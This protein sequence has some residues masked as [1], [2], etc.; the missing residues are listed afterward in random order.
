MRSAKGQKG[1][2]LLET[3]IS[4]PILM[5]L[6][7]ASVA[8]LLISVRNYFRVLAD[9]ELHQE[10]QIAFTRMVQDLTEAKYVTPYQQNYPGIELHKRWYAL[11][12]YDG[13]TDF[14]TLYWI[15]EVRGRKKLIWGWD[16]SAPMTGDYSLAGVEIHEIAGE[17]EASSPGL[18]VL[19]LKG[20]SVFTNHYYTLST[21]VYLPRGEGEGTDAR[22]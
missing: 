1:I 7:T 12:D 15:A 14:W 4:L 22:E 5:M 20:R 19:R 11:R 10:M 13:C 6:L 3:A 18:Y 2:I 17:E 9:A 16:R 21:V 8:M